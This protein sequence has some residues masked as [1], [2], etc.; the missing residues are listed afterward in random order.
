MQIFPSIA[1]FTVLDFELWAFVFIRLASMLFIMPIIGSTQV[2]VKVRVGLSLF[3]SFVVFSALNTGPMD[4][5]ETLPEFFLLAI[6][7]IFL[8]IVMGFAGSL[9]FAGLNIAGRLIDINAGFAMVQS[10]NP[11]TEANE[12][13]VGQI[14]TI[15]FTLV[16]IVTSAHLFFVR[17]CI[18]SF[19][20]IPLLKVNV[21][22]SKIASILIF[23]TSEAFVYGVKL[24]APVIVP[25]LLATTGL[26]IMARIMPQM[27]VWLVGMP[28]KI[29][30]GILTI[31]FVLPLT[32][33]VFQKELDS[34]QF[35]QMAMMKIFGGT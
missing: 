14:K 26:A 5:P 2:P 9:V 3:I 13:I 10:I 16:L 25:L 31:I 8:G 32:W 6:R 33:E 34:V 21:D 12:S 22:M 1:D 4:L 19:Q 17:I 28:L 30:L 20:V 7:E 18:E 27:N 29:G 23:L 24:S 35:Y 15:V 11:M